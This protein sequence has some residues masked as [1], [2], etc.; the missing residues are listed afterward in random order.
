VWI[1][2]QVA[3][4]TT[5]NNTNNTNTTNNTN[6]TTNTNTNNTTN[7]NMYVPPMMMT[8]GGV[9]ITWLRNAGLMTFTAPRLPPSPPLPMPL[10]LTF[11]KCPNNDSKPPRRNNVSEHMGKTYLGNRLS[12][13]FGT[14][15]HPVVVVVVVVVVKVY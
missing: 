13:H 1:G 12:I 8:A 5:D 3:K 15:M 10:D 11:L 14:F 4:G 7:T 9:D 6:N 2:A